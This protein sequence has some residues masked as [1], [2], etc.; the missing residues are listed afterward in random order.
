[1][2]STGTVEAQP[3]S[4]WSMDGGESTRSRGTDVELPLS[5]LIAFSFPYRRTPQTCESC[6]PSVS[7]GY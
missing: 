2:S 6:L 1:M 7:D 4:F 5:E 3:A